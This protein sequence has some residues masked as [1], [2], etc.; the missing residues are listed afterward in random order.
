M[1]INDDT[2]PGIVVYCGLPRIS[3][4]QL[5]P[6]IFLVIR[7]F[8][9]EQL[10]MFSKLV[11]FSAEC[12][13]ISFPGLLL[14]FWANCF[15]I[16]Y[17][18]YSGCTVGRQKRSIP[19]RQYCVYVKQCTFLFSLFIVRP[20]AVKVDFDGQG[21]Q[22]GGQVWLLHVCLNWDGSLEW[23]PFCSPTESVCFIV[24]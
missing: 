9:T 1:E 6:R 21:I 17:R 24:V 18:S 15:L 7:E 13:V 12:L 20:S 8:K 22:S 2:N 5:K 23:F 4:W 11:H 10:A 16:F 19:T 3:R 14:H